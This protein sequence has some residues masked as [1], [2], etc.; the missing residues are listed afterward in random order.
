MFFIHYLYVVSRPST[1]KTN[2]AHDVDD[3][4]GTSSS[5]PNHGQHSGDDERKKKSGSSPEWSLFV[6]MIL[7][8]IM[9]FVGQVLDTLRRGTVKKDALVETEK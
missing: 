6:I 2:D 4:D 5:D 3:D 1:T 8:A 7:E 9:G